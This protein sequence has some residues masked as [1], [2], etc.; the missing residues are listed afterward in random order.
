MINLPDS[1]ET[2]DESKKA[3]FMELKEQKEKGKKVV[4]IFCSYTPVE[5]VMA[6]GACFVSL[7]GSGEESIAVAET[8][9][10]KNLCPLVKSSYGVALSGSCPYFYFSDAILAETTCDGKK[11]MYELLGELKPVH[12]MHLPQMQND[13]HSLSL[14]TAE[15]HRAKEFLEKQLSVTITD[16][17]LRTAIKER[18]RVRRSLLRLY[19]TARMM[20]SPV[21]GY[22]LSTIVDATDFHFTDDDLVEILENKIAE[23]TSR[24]K[25]QDPSQPI[26]PR[27]LITGCPIGGAREKVLQT[28]E[29]LGADVVAFDSCSGPRTQ[30]ELVDETKDPYEALA[31]KYMRINCSVMTPNTSRFE[32]L[33]QMADDYH[34]DGVVEVVL[35][36]CHTFAVESYY[37]RKYISEEKKLPY[38]YIETDYSTT[39][40]AQ[41]R[42]RLGAFLEML[43]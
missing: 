2:F 13:P 6:T 5:L 16:D 27:I 41:I 20:P 24:Y 33:G 14:W 7:C 26:R 12:V 21:S 43:Q 1:F 25:P 18:N 28:I 3:G 36:A 35:H 19:E 29:E 38:T 4:G 17:A 37:T 23:I 34:V 22:E 31:E 30:R 9:L 11:K 39:D 8:R 10:P 42:T 15:M 32:E 40:T